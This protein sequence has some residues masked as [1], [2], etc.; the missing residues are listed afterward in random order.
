MRAP[1]FWSRNGSSWG[2]ALA[3]LGWAYGL[4]TRL[5]LARIKPWRAPV[6][7]ICIANVVAGGAGKTPVAL[8]LGERLIGQGRKVHFLSRGFGGTEAGPLRVDPKKHSARDVGDEPLL[9]ARVGPTWVSAE[10]VAGAQEASAGPDGPDVIIMD[11]GFQNPGVFKDLSLLVVDGDYGFGNGQ[12][13]PAGPLREPVAAALSRAAAVVLIG[14]DAAGVN[15]HLALQGKDIPVLRA[16]IKP[17]PETAGLKGKPVFAFAGIAQ[18]EKFFK[19]LKDTDLD[20]KGTRS[21]P[22]HHPFGRGD[23]E[24]LKVA[25]M[26]AGA[27]LVTTEKDAV[28]LPAA[29]RE[30]V[31][32]LGISLEWRDETA[33]DSIIAPIF[34]N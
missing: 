33:L 13:I 31:E 8:S 6:P 26:D 24:A 18:P 9:L 30:E 10:R 1:D 34:K 32:V 16:N 2:M 29:D 5:R 25:A 7:V 27:T 14:E 20:I 28:R 4:S 3:P 11:D 22:D 21:F 15:N 19:S 23:L 12:M 17:D